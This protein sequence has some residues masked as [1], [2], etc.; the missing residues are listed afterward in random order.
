MSKEKDVSEMTLE[1]IEEQ[2]EREGGFQIHSED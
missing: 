1:E 2:I